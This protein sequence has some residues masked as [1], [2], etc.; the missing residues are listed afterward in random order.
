[1]IN[2]DCVRDIVFFLDSNFEY[3]HNGIL[4]PIKLKSVIDGY[5]FNK[6]LESEVYLAI[7]YI[8]DKSLVELAKPNCPPRLSIF[9][10]ITPLGY[11]FLAA[12]KDETVWSKVKKESKDLAKFTIQQMISLA[13]ASIL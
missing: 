2:F 3:R 13:L 8:V 9:I 10:K 12:V 1:M 6:Y 11:D 5:P 7:E 4:H